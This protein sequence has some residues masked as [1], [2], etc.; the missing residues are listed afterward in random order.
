MR[1]VSLEQYEYE[2]M[3]NSNR[4]TSSTTVRYSPAPTAPRLDAVVENID[5]VPQSRGPLR[6]PPP[7]SPPPP[8]L[9]SEY[10][11]PVVVM[12]FIEKAEKRR[13]RLRTDAMLRVALFEGLIAVFMLSGGVWCFYDTPEYCPYFSAIWTSTAL[14]LNTLLGIVAAKRATVNLFIAHLVLSLIS[15]MLCVIGAAISARNWLLIGTYQ[16]PKIERNQA[17]C[18]IGENDASRLRYIFTQLNRYDFKQCLLQL[19][20][21]VAVNSL[22]FVGAVIEAVLNLVSSILCCRQTCTRCFGN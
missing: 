4:Q 8:P 20:V 5:G 16:H 17:F 15:L 3:I 18:L 22:Q 19:K 6:E 14:L 10:A 9:A 7:Y 21:G 2:N 12:N 11:E 1:E 13:R